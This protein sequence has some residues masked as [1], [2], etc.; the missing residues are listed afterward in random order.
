[1]EFIRMKHSGDVQNRRFIIEAAPLVAI[2]AA[3]VAAVI[4]TE[5]KP[6][7]LDGLAADVGDLRTS[8]SAARLLATE[9]MNGDLT[10]TFTRSNADLIYSQVRSIRKDLES[11]EPEQD[12]V[13]EHW[14]AR[15]YAK[16][17]EEAAY[18]MANDSTG[19]GIER[20]RAG[21]L[22]QQFRDLEDKLK[23]HPKE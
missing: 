6:L 4:A 9:Y 14:E 16:Q 5:L 23:A 7:S 10:D 18:R 20:N 2:V 3:I 15:H 19:I 21:E 1:M 13:L 17:L 11:S 8:A 12:I 22:I